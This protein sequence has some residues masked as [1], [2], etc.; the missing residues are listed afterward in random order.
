MHCIS[1]L[2]AVASIY[3]SKLY[4]AFSFL[5]Y[6]PIQSLFHP[7]MCTI[8]TRKR[9]FPVHLVDKKSAI[10]TVAFRVYA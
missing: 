10:P 8:M 6:L 3:N 2:H 7:D 1:Y 4:A 9:I 5:F